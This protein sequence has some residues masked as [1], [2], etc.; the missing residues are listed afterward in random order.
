MNL[1]FFFLDDIKDPID[2]P[3]TLD[4]LKSHGYVLIDGVLHDPN[5]N[6]EDYMYY[7]DSAFMK[8][9]PSEIPKPRQDAGYKCLVC[10]IAL[11]RLKE[12]ITHVLTLHCS[13]GDYQCTLCNTQLLTCGS[14]KKHIKNYHFGFNPFTCPMCKKS[15]QQKSHLKTHI[16]KQHGGKKSLFK[17]ALA[18]HQK[19]K[20]QMFPKKVTSMPRRTSTTTNTYVKKDES[21]TC[22]LCH[23]VSLIEYKNLE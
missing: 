1:I 22:P 23:K 12:V 14:V 13:K 15:I 19:L 3:Y 11:F 17:K 16:E 2:I 18:N 6:E 7:N 20:A 21:L 9:K 5:F 10:N 4:D 8:T